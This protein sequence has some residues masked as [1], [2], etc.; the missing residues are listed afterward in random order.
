MSNS[1]E[2]VATYVGNASSS[3]GFS[4]YYPRP[5]YQD[6]AVRTYLGKLGTKWAPYFN[7]DGRGFPDISAQSLNLMYVNHNVTSNLGAGTRYVQAFSPL[8]PF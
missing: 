5:R 4:D 1:P 2:V 3:G 8:V 7:R 6:D